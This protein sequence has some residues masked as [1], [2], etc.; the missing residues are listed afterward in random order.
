MRGS[1]YTKCMR[2]EIRTGFRY[3][4]TQDGGDN[5]KDV[6]LGGRL[7]LKCI[8]LKYSRNVKDTFMSSRI[9]S[10]GY[11]AQREIS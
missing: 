1:G 2:R 7:I 6:C 3:E 4:N 8:S 10:F 9:G 11:H 5:L